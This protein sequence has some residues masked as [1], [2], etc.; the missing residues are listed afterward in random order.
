MIQEANRPGFVLDSRRLVFTDGR[1]QPFHRCRACG[2][3]QFSNVNHRCTGF[4]CEGVLERIN[5]EERRKWESEEH[6]HRLYLA[7]FCAGKVVREHTA[8]INNQLRERLERQFRD[9][10]VSVL[11]CSTTMELGVD[12]GELEAVVCRNVPPGIQ[13]Y[14]QRTGRAGRRAQ[15]APVCVTTA[16]SR[17]YDQAEFRRAEE[18]LAEK[19]R[20]PFVHLENV[21]LFRRHQFSVML[22]GLMFRLGLG[23]GTGGS[24]E[25]SSFFGK[26]FSVERE[27]EFLALA[28]MWLDSADGLACINEAL[29]LASGL[30]A[31]LGCTVAELR[32]QFLGLNRDGEGLRGMSEWYGHRWRY[33]REHYQE[34]HSLGLPGQKQA[35]YW[36]YQLGK[37]QEQ[38]LINQFPKL[39]FLPT[40]SFPVNSVQLE[41]LTEEKPAQN[42]RPWEQDIQLVRDARLGIAEYAP[43]AQVVAAGRVWESVGIGE[44]PR[45]FM[46]PRFYH[47]CP[48]CRHAQVEEER[49][50]FQAACEVCGGPRRPHDVRQFIEPKSFVTSASQPKGRDPGLTRLRPPPAQE[51]RLL[52]GASESDFSQQPTGVPDTQ[53]AWQDAQRGRMLVINKGRK[54]GFYHCRCGYA[55]ALK[56]PGEWPQV[57]AAAHD[58]PYGMRCSFTDGAQRED[59]G[60]EFRTDVLQI[61]FARPVP[62]PLEVPLEER[63]VWE[64]GFLRTLVEAV[65]QAAARLLEIE[66]REISGTARLWRFGY[67]EIVLYDTVAGGAGYCQMLSQRG[68]RDLL[69]RTLKALDCPAKCSHSCRTCLQTYGNQV[70][71]NQLNRLPALAWLKHLLDLDPP[72]NPF[73]SFDAVPLEGVD[74]RALAIAELGHAT[75]LVATSNL[76][77]PITPD[78]PDGEPT[79]PNVLLRS[80]LEMLARGHRIELALPGEPSISADYPASLEVAAKLAPFQKSGNFKLWRLPIGFD[81]RA[82]PRWLVQSGRGDGRALF[83]DSL[84]ET[85]FLQTP[86]ISPLWRGPAL[87]GA[88]EAKFR[89]GWEPLNSLETAAARTRIYDYASGTQRDFAR[90]FSFLRKG[91]RLDLL[92][93]HDPYALKA[94]RNLNALMRFLGEVRALLGVWPTKT[95]VRVR[96]DFVGERASFE[97]WLASQPAAG[98]VTPVTTRGPDRKDFHDRQVLFIPNAAAP[99]ARTV[100]LL[101]GG[102]DRYMEP[103][104]ETVVIVHRPQ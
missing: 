71:W 3:R 7:E 6:Y 83:S 36:A 68:L 35:N 77:L 12:I 75:H 55:R 52:S 86:L 54:D 72:A 81:P 61:R 91:A 84:G 93:I 46:K 87:E 70:Y 51:A 32:E 59:L 69:K 100:V 8:A 30:P 9:G 25:L 64:D 10:E 56:N 65:R 1:D 82:W 27:R 48:A 73:A 43:G 103:E 74:P 37:W 13:N 63:G 38:L 80:I 42:R 53:W 2:L 66:E 16:M 67:P 47:L 29:D 33:F 40:Y 39:G 19:P 11:S 102:V 99:N 34:A 76:L 15:S 14:Q 23:D 98:C 96:A 20:T 89:F 41:V 88:E 24:P 4:R 44:Y 45:H 31:T 58:T 18:Y 78:S 28:A 22:R 94:P 92:S 49:E 62:F 79:P 17:N 50:D 101:T 5:E 97:Q 60:H 21:R 95:E 104:C 90:D 57:A 85:C 26:E